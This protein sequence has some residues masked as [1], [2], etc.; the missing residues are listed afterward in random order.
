MTDH[1]IDVFL[2]LY[3]LMTVALFIG[4]TCQSSQNLEASTPQTLETK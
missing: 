4:A 1:Q 2:D 3:I